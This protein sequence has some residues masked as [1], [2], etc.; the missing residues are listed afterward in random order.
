L[1]YSNN[2]LRKCSSATTS[3]LYYGKQLNSS[4]KYRTKVISVNKNHSE[5]WHKV[6]NTERQIN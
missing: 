5:F 6:S 1:A 2:E 4:P 3:A